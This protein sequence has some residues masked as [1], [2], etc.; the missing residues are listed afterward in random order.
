MGVQLVEVSSIEGG[1]EKNSDAGEVV[2]DWDVCVDACL[3]RAFACICIF[4]IFSPYH[5]PTY[6]NTTM[7]AHNVTVNNTININITN[8]NTNTGST[9]MRAYQKMILGA[10]GLVLIAVLGIFFIV[11]RI[12]L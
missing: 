2:V 5:S 8:T 7:N 12:L 3:L 4:Y 6:H 11:S 1:V 9:K 10:L